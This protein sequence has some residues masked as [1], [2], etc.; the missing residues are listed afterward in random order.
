M[1]SEQTRRLG[2]L[3]KVVAEVPRYHDSP[4]YGR[5]DVGIDEV[6][7][8]GHRQRRKEDI[9]GPT[10]AYRRRCQQCRREG[11]LA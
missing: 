9:Y 3:R 7:E 5:I 1:M 8:C 6:L 4:E 10:N 2:P 11:R